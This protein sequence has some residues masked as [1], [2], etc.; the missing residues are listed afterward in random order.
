MALFTLCFSL[1]SSLVAVTPLHSSCELVTL[2][3]VNTAVARC[4]ALD[5]DPITT[6]EA[7]RAGALKWFITIR[8]LETNPEF[9]ATPPAGPLTPAG[10][11]GRA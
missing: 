5:K 2:T 3:D 11:G 10:K 9:Q 6:C 4:A 7:R 8:Q 1:F